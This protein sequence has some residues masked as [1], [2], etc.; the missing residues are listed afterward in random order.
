MEGAAE[1][2]EDCRGAVGGTGYEEVALGE[3]YRGWYR[4][5]VGKNHPH[6]TFLNTL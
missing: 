4:V 3:V 1:R 5:A 6:H 2:E